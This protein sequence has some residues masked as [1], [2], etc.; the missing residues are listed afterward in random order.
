[1]ETTT[2]YVTEEE[3]L[4]RYGPKDRVELVDGEVIPKYGAEGPLSP[5]SGAHGRIVRN[6]LFA[7]ESYVRSRGRGEV[8]TDPTAFVISEQPRRI[9]CP[10]VACVEAG[11]LPDETAMGPL[12][13][14]APDLAAEVIAPSE[15]ALAVDAKVDLYLECGVRLVWKVDPKRRLVT[16]Y[17]PD[18]AT[19]PTT[20]D[21]TL[22]GRDVLPDFALPL[23]EL[24]VGV[25]R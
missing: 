5:T 21:G 17:T 7:L 12:F 22:T 2:G 15:P 9:R 16:A 8:Y 13:R 3:F 4:A 10:D 11:R 6:L 14:L 1:M 24:F 20:E 25:A 18:G 23:R 19:S